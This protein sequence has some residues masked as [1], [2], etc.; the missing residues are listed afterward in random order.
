MVSKLIEY[1]KYCYLD[2]VMGFVT[3]PCAY[4]PRFSAVS[5]DVAKTTLCVTVVSAKEDPPGKS[6]TDA[7]PSLIG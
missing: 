3:E 7:E 4:L 5:K 1:V 2:F 6:Q